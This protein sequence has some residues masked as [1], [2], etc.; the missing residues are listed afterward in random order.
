MVSCDEIVDPADHGTGAQSVTAVTA[1]S[2]LEI[3]HT[4]QSNAIR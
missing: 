2:I 1:G 4:G 3:K